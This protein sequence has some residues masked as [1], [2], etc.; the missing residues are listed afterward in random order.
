MLAVYNVT[1]LC[2]PT[3]PSSDVRDDVE[4]NEADD[5]DLTLHSSLVYPWLAAYGDR[6]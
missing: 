5:F 4:F 6:V 3:S 1:L 2:R